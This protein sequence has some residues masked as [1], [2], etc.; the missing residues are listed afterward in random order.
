MS[1]QQSHRRT[2]MRRR[3]SWPRTTLSRLR[4][5]RHSSLKLRSPILVSAPK[6]FAAET[7]TAAPPAPDTYLSAARR[8]ARAAAAQVEAEHS[9]RTGG[10]AWGTTPFDEDVE[11]RSGS[12]RTTIVIGIIALVLILAIV[13]GAVLSQRISG[14][15]PRSAS[16]LFD[17][18]KPAAPRAVIAK[19]VAAKPTPVT[20]PA[21]PVMNTVVIPPTDNGA[22][23]AT[24]PTTTASTTEKPIDTHAVAS[25]PVLPVPQ[26]HSGTSSAAVAPVVPPAPIDRLTKLATAG[27]AKAELIVGLKYLD[28]DGVPVSEPDAAKWL[29]RA[30][31]AGLPVAQYRLGTMFERGRGVTADAAKSVHWYALAAQAGNRKAMHN[32]AVAY[33]SGSG[34]AKNLSEAARWF[35]KA[36]ALGLSEL[37]VQPRRSI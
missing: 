20:A 32:L 4:K 33:A 10:F 7:L 26:T 31:E 25:A 18:A 34:V 29:E 2:K 19:A 12:R 8:S 23:V 14:T 11:T 5:R 21:L 30:A 6:S 13:A 27:N 24:T 17:N 9:P 35:S 1:L 3:P 22:V 28:G 16:A 37:P 36:A 15:S